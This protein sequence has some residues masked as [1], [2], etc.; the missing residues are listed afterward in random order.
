MKTSIFPS[1]VPS[2]ELFKRSFILIFSFMWI[3]F[4]ILLQKGEM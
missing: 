1:N 3:P 2:M 4:I